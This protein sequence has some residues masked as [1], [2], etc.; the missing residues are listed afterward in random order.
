MN[1][2]PISRTTDQI[3]G[4][5]KNAILA[6]SR[7]LK[8]ISFMALITR[9]STKCSRKHSGIEIHHAQ[10]Y[11]IVTSPFI[12]QLLIRYGRNT[13]ILPQP[14]SS[15]KNNINK[16]LIQR[17][18][19]IQE[20]SPLSNRFKQLIHIG[21]FR[22]HING[23]NTYCTCRQNISKRR[24][25]RRIFQSIRVPN[26][27][28]NSGHS[29]RSQHLSPRLFFCLGKRHSRLHEIKTPQGFKMRQNI[30][31]HAIRITHI[32]KNGIRIYAYGPRPYHRYQNIRTF[33][34]YILESKYTFV[35]NNHSNR[36]IRYCERFRIQLIK[37]NN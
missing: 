8:D 18:I 32:R 22:R 25:H 31:I 2:I 11:L 33:K 17:R 24:N 21:I 15:P 7:S 1:Q 28:S 13:E 14:I 4:R 27:I 6:L 19:N 26:I 20:S 9:S 5:H 35:I 16:V 36:R 37:R 3:I 10:P 30:D 29:E 34:R 23:V 12:T